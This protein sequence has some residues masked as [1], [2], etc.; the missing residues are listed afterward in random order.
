MSEHEDG[1]PEEFMLFGMPLSKFPKAPPI[2][3]REPTLWELTKMGFRPLDL[4]YPL[5]W[6]KR[7]RA[8]LNRGA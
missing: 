7:R 4:G 1:A 6:L 3:T 8:R 5:K 2:E